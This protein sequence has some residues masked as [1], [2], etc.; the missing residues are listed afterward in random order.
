[1]W[2]P[3]GMFGIITVHNKIIIITK[4]FC[5]VVDILLNATERK[6]HD[7]MQYSKFSHFQSDLFQ[8]GFKF[9]LKYSFGNSCKIAQL[10]IKPTGMYT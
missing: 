3:F 8:Y 7:S 1:M 5:F 4:D 9:F 2:I 10:E 6:N